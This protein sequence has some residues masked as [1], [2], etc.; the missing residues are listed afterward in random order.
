MAMHNLD[1]AAHFRPMAQRSLSWF[2]RG[3]SVVL[4]AF[5]ATGLMAIPVPSVFAWGRIGHR[6]SARVAEARLTP[7]ARAALRALLEPGESLADLSTWADE[8]RP[9]RP[10]TGPWHYVNVPL[11]ESRYDARFCPARGCVVGKIQEFRSRLADR[12]ASRSER[13]DALR[14]L[15]HFVQDLHQPLHVGERSD[16]GGNDLQVQFLGQGSNLHRVWDYGLFERRYRDDVALSQ[17]IRSVLDTDAASK[18]RGGT[19]EDWATE[20]LLAAR[21]AYTAVGTNRPLRKGAR[22]EASYVEAN[23]PMARERLAASALRLA[24]MLEAALVGPTPGPR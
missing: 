12:T 18:W 3:R 20:S 7:A 6:A 13:R 5:V 14:F 11:T 23:L 22:L 17:A 21:Q 16:R 10:E 15:V 1:D 9:D 19:V 24:E 8:V 4:V 2:R